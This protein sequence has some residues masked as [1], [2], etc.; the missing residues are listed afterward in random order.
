M[1]GIGQQVK[2]ESVMEDGKKKVTLDEKFNWKYPLAIAMLIWAFWHFYLYPVDD[3]IDL[4][5]A[6]PKQVGGNN[7]Q[8]RY[9]SIQKINLANWY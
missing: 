9:E 3:E 8:Q 2:L 5:N 6:A 1:F 7:M 4:S